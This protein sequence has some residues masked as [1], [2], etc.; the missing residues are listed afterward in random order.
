V[1]LRPAVLVTISPDLCFFSLSSCRLIQ[2]QKKIPHRERAP[3]FA[4]MS[5]AALFLS[6]YE[7]GGAQGKQAVYMLQKPEESN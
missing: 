6:G 7:V 1:P 3:W 5:F 2:E 4:A